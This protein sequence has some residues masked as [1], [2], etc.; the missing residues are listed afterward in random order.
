MYK[1]RRLTNIEYDREMRAAF[2]KVFADPFSFR[3]FAPTIAN[4][5]VL[6]PV[7]WKLDKIEFSAVISA[8]K[9]IGDKEIYLSVHNKIFPSVNEQHD[10]LAISIDSKD[11]YHAIDE[12]EV[13][14]WHQFFYS[15]SGIWGIILNEEEYAM[16]GGN[17]LFVSTLF[18]NLPISHEDQLQNFLRMTRAYS[19]QFRRSYP[20]LSELLQHLYGRD[21]ADRL[22]SH[23][24]AE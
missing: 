7:G 20:G 4:R 11:A 17:Q 13:S 21:T 24:V 6:Y 2:D 18:A 12:A 16:V 5:A 9:A 15:A 8:V 3:P 23:T 10:H 22:L 14:A 1:P 19:T